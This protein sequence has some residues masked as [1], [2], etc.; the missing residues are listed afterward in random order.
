[1]EFTGYRCDDERWISSENVGEDDAHNPIRK[2]DGAPVQAVKLEPDQ[3]EKKGDRF[4]LISDPEIRIDSRAHKMSKARGNVVNPDEIVADYGADSLR[5][6]EMFMGPLEASKPWSM[7]GVK[8]VR[9]FLDRVWR[10]IVDEHSEDV[11]LN[12]SIVDEEPDEEQLRVLHKTI[13]A[14]TNDIDMLS[15]NTAIARYMEFVNHF[16]KQTHR[17]KL[18]MN[19]FVLILAPMAPHIAEELWAVLGNSDSLALHA[20][21]KHDETLATDSSLEIPISI[22]GK[23]RSKL[24]VARG[25]SKDEL[26]KLALAD[27]RIVELL[28]DKTVRKIIVVPDRMVN[29]VAN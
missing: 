17:P 26:E 20:W 8:G 15:F 2:S 27:E 18:I 24:N 29:I 12:E 13:K 3:V 28:T 21:P 19:Q 11:Q 5:L 4:S 9:N 25:T 22:Q 1:M 10:M 23:V 16:T 6:Y 14:V 7:Q